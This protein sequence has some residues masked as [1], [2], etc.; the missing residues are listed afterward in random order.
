M[1]GESVGMVGKR[2]SASLALY[3]RREEPDK[4]YGLS[5]GHGVT[6]GKESEFIGKRRNG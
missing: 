6:P 2:E 5:V 3:L 4:V 1:L